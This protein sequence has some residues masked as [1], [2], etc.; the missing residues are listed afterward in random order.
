M[1][2]CLLSMENTSPIGETPC[3]QS[4]TCVD[5]TCQILCSGNG[6]CPGEHLVCKEDEMGNM[7]CF[8]LTPD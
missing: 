5:D 1:T 6:G 4:M 3:A 2:L 8:D 7:I